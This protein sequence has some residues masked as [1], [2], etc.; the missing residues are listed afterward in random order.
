[1][2]FFKK[3]TMKQLKAE[4]KKLGTK[5]QSEMERAKVERD[6]QRIKTARG[7]TRKVKYQKGVAIAKKAGSG[8][9]AFMDKMNENMNKPSKKKK[10]MWF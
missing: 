2:S 10:D 6:I 3:K 9:M 4:R 1:M 8:F 5:L 7:R